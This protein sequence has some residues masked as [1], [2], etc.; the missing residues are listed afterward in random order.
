MSQQYYS[1]ANQYS[2][3]NN[4]DYIQALVSKEVKKYSDQ[5]R[6]QNAMYNPKT[7]FI[8]V[9]GD[10]VEKF[11]SSAWNN[12]PKVSN[13]EEYKRL[14]ALNAS[15]QKNDDQAQY[16]F[17]EPEFQDQALR[18]YEAYKA[19][20]AAVITSTEF[21]QLTVNTVS[22]AL[23]NRQQL[24][25]QK[26]NLLGVPEK[27]TVQDTINI[28]YPEYNNTTSTVRVGYKENEAI[29][30]SG[31]GAFT[32]TSVT[33]KKAGAG[34]AFTEEYYMKQFT[35][36]IQALI[37]DKIALDFTAARYNRIITK[38]ATLTDL[39]TTQGLWSAY[40]ATNLASTNRPYTDI[41]AVRV[42]VNADKLATVNT[43]ISNQQ[44]FI[45][46]YSNTWVKGI[47]TQDGAA[48]Q[49]LNQIVANP[50][51]LP[52][53]NQWIINEDTPAGH[54]FIFDSRFIV[55]IEGPR[56]T[57]Q[58]NTYN[59]DQTVFIQKEWFDIVT[60]STRTGWGRELTGV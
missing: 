52:F 7:G 24:V 42:A 40:T 56:K 20:G 38:L 53:I 32:Q 28:V 10:N 51:G 33:L 50:P 25:A 9:T 6:V 26:Y 8:H 45:D 18:F 46:F 54:A 36:D 31:Y 59:P 22:Q 35:M 60:P 21:P 41:N 15:G 14:K 19:K 34:L 4:Q 29:D 3:N 37:L 48:T 1:A 23:L 11:D 49:N 55:D 57:Q 2:T 13:H 12:W 27:L 5:G 44:L 30:T 58:I 39:A 43:I 16:N 17:I 47:F